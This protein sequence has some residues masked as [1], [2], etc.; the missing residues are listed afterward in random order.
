M[1]ATGAATPCTPEDL[2][3]MPDSERFELIDGELVEQHTS[4]WST[5]VAGRL[6]RRM[7][8]HCEARQLGWVAPEGASYACFPP[9]RG[10]IRRADVSFIAG[11]RLPVDQARTEGHL[12]IAPD[13]AVEVVS[14]NDLVYEVADKVRDYLDAGVRLVWVINPE[15]RTAEIHRG[16][17]QGVILH[18]NDELDGEDVLPGFRCRL[19]DLFQPPPGVAPTAGNAP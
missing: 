8:A 6:F 2:L 1:S 12:P 7:D 17:G 11:G 13:L 19:G 14:P 3:K 4:F 16:Q 9:G 18:E 5:F 10:N 15:S